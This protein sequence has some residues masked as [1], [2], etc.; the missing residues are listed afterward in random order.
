M[1]EIPERQKTA[2]DKTIEELEQEIEKNNETIKE[3]WNHIANMA[4]LCVWVATIMSIVLGNN[5]RIWLI[6]WLG[7]GALWL[8][9]AIL[10]HVDELQEFSLVR[11]TNDIFYALSDTKFKKL[12]I[13][14]KKKRESKEE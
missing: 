10:Y 8:V 13:K 5:E 3:K 11:S 14:E 6:L 4:T 2:D 7:W 9:E 12:M 1:R